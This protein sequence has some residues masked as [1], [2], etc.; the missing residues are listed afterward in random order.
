MH[1]G[2][3]AQ[4]RFAVTPDRAEAVTVDH[5]RSDG[6][7]ATGSDYTATSGT[8]SFAAGETAKTVS[9]P[10]LDESD[11]PSSTR[12][13]RRMVYRLRPDPCGGRQETSVPNRRVGVTPILFLFLV[14]LVAM[15]WVGAR[16]AAAGRP[17][18]ES[19][20]ARPSA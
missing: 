16:G 10:V 18:L 7:A 4:L 8:L 20:Q 17:A 5:A 6:A 12:G 11:F 2:P 1:E 15:A 14:G 9:V 3:Q 13:R 19:L